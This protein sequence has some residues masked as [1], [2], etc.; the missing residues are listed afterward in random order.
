MDNKKMA[1]YP[2]ERIFRNLSRIQVPDDS[3]LPK[4]PKP[5]WHMM[6]DQYSKFKITCF[7][8]TK[9]GMVEPTC[10][11]FKKWENKVIQLKMCVKIMPVK[12]KNFKKDQIQK[13]G[14]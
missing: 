4:V 11:L 14:N 10:A 5:N 8:K 7:Y 2:K 1:E 9:D 13:I 6:V 3:D 12:I